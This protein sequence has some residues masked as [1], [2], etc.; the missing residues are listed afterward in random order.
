MSRLTPSSWRPS[1]IA[2]EASRS[3]RSVRSAPV[4]TSVTRVV[5]A[6]RSRSTRSWVPSSSANSSASPKLPPCHGRQRSARSIVAARAPL[7][8]RRPNRPVTIASCRVDLPASFGPTTRFMAGPNRRSIA[9]RLPKPSIWIRVSRMA[10]PPRSAYRSLFEGVERQLQ[11]PPGRLFLLPRFALVVDQLSHH[12]A[13]AGEF[14]CSP[15]EVVRNPRAVVTLE[16]RE[17]VAA[18]HGERFGIQAQR[19]G[20]FADQGGANHP[21]FEMLTLAQRH[22]RVADMVGAAHA[23][24]VDRLLREPP[25]VDIFQQNLERALVVDGDERGAVSP[26]F[27]PAQRFRAARIGDPIA[28]P[29]IVVMTEQR[30]AKAGLLD[31]VGQDGLVGC[32]TFGQLAHVGAMQQHQVRAQLLADDIAQRCVGNLGPHEARG[33]D[34]DAAVA[35]RAELLVSGDRDVLRPA[36]VAVR[37]ARHGRIGMAG[38]DQ[39]RN[40]GGAQRLHDEAGRLARDV[41]VL[42]EVATAGDQVHLVFAGTVDDPLQR[43]PEIFAA[44]LGTD[45]VEALAREG[46]V[47]MQVSEMEQA[48]GHKSPVTTRIVPVAMA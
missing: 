4:P 33:P 32:D 46:S 7:P 34:L 39:H 3:K 26:G 27:V 29:G 14:L 10:D 18:F 1:W 24:D 44:P 16:V 15:I 5:S 35:V 37:R 8:E 31:L 9:C 17:A 36:Q 2:P 38:G 45:S 13:P 19:P 11:R 20:A 22:D 12:L 25:L 42:E 30:V 48:K 6:S 43:G 28:R 47:E 40:A 41:V 21:T 23:G